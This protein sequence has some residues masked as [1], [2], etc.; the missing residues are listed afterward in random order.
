MRAKFVASASTLNLCLTAR[1]QPR[2]RTVWFWLDRSLH[3][4]WLYLIEKPPFVIICL[5]AFDSVWLWVN[6]WCFSP[7]GIFLSSSVRSAT[8]SANPSFLYIPLWEHLL[9]HS[10]WICLLCSIEWSVLSF[11][12][13]L[14]LVLSRALHDAVPDAV[15]WLTDI[16]SERAAHASWKVRVLQYSSHSW[17]AHFL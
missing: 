7:D 1:I 13:T 9:G 10:V 6:Y 16:S 5:G 8:F 3:S 4:Y 12:E 15:N 17:L 11:W 14:I 2:V